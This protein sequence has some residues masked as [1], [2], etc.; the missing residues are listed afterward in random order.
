MAKN[1]L[2][3]LIIPIGKELAGWSGFSIYIIAVPSMNPTYISSL[4][5]RLQFP[6]LQ[7][8]GAVAAAGADAPPNLNI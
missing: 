4:K 1:V 5:F 6:N 2:F 8:P 3:E 7:F